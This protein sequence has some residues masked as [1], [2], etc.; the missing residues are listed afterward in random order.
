MIHVSGA[1]TLQSCRQCYQRTVQLFKQWSQP[2]MKINMKGVNQFD[3]AVLTLMLSWLR[4]AKSFGITVAYEAVPDDIQSIS[5]L[6]G[7]SD[8]L[9]VTN[10]GI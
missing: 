8:L 1:I 7:T 3:S 6:F 10:E 2:S 5:Q 9:P 4:L